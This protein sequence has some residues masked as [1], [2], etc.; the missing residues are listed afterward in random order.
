MSALGYRCTV[1]NRYSALTF[2]SQWYFSQERIVEGLSPIIGVSEHLLSTKFARTQKR[3]WPTGQDLFICL[4]SA[5][6]YKLI[7]S[8]KAASQIIFQFYISLPIGIRIT[9][10]SYKLSEFILSLILGICSNIISQN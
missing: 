1:T 6:T 8:L 2:S 5:H 7:I 10:D 4:C 9:S 3:S